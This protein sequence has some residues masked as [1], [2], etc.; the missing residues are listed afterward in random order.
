MFVVFVILMATDLRTPSKSIISIAPTLGRDP[1]ATIMT[2]NL[3]TPTIPSGAPISP[4]NTIILDQQN[5][6]QGMT[7]KHMYQR[8]QKMKIQI[9]F[10]KELISGTNAPLETLIPKVGKVIRTPSMGVDLARTKETKQ[11]ITQWTNNLGRK[12]KQITVSKQ[13]EQ[14][15]ESLGPKV[16]WGLVKA[17]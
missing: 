4:H 15:D 16:N 11:K 10:L 9:A 1:P 8:I 13:E 2:Q 5:L 7:P 17:V 12:N 14:Y 3:T 6:F